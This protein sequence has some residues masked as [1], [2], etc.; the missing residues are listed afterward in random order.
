MSDVLTEFIESYVRERE[1]LATAST[2][3]KGKGA[4]SQ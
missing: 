1:I 3:V 4:R 2:G